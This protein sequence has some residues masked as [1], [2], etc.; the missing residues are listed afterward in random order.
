MNIENTII[1]LRD[2]I[3]RAQTRMKDLEAGNY[4]Q[5]VRIR[6]LESA[7]NH[8][9]GTALSLA[10]ARIKNLTTENAELGSHLIKRGIQY[11]DAVARIKELETA[12][13][14][15]AKAYEDYALD[16]THLTLRVSQYPASFTAGDLRR[17]AKAMEDTEV[18]R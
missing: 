4:R 12:L 15:F 16:D 8:A 14:P 17:A 3:E 1:D 6:Y 9:G 13:R 18:E 5:R 7:T 11:A 10:E 2:W